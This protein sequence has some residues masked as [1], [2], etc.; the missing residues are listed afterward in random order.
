MTILPPKV[1]SGRGRVKARGKGQG[2]GREKREP[3]FKERAGHMALGGSGARGRELWTPGQVGPMWQAQ[4]LVM[5]S[6]PAGRS[7]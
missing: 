6:G 3:A 2:P 1:E 5:G 4:P 7:R